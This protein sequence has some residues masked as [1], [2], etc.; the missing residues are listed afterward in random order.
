MSP[1]ARNRGQSEPLGVVLLLGIVLL[2]LAL[3]GALAAEGINGLSDRATAATNDHDASQL[4]TELHAVAFDA[5]ESGPAIIGLGSG[6]TPL[7]VVLNATTSPVELVVDG[8]TV[9]VDDL[10]RLAFTRSG[11]EFGIEGGAAFRRAS[12]FPAMIGDPPIAMRD[13]P[14]TLLVPLIVLEGGATGSN[15][16]TVER[17]EVVNAYPERVVAA[18]T[19][20]ELSVESEY[21]EAWARYFESIGT[22]ESAVVTVD[23]AAHR[24]T[25]RLEGGSPRYV[26]FVVYRLRVSL[27]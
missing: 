13:D 15:R 8:E 12:D 11:I 25:L 6:G 24:A 14:P 22:D 4:V 16:V 1:S 9:F 23:D 20:V 10:G 26:Q 27:A 17:I 2:G 19:V 18:G 7:T 5:H 21:Y 3:M